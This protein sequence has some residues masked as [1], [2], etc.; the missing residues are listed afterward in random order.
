[1]P[2][3]LL[4]A[5]RPWA[6][7]DIPFGDR[8]FRVPPLTAD[9]WLELLVRDEISLWSILPGLLEEE[10][11]AGH[12]QDVMV[13]GVVSRDQYEE[14]VWDVVGVAAGREWFTAIYLLGNAIDP[15]HGDFVRG[16]LVLAGVDASRI[17]LAAFLDVIYFIFA[18][19]MKP[20]DKQKF[21]MMLAKPPGG[22][23]P[24]IDP[25]KQKSAFSALMATG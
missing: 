12:F 1:M 22:V 3:D 10:D 20:L 15:T 6:I 4:A 9:R 5:V 7:E 13:T 11:A 25:Q 21:D 23:K 17:S 24:K 19:H 8:V 16:E 18:R 2:G 14:L